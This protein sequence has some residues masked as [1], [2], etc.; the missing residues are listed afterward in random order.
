[1]K[2]DI[3]LQQDVMAE[4]QWEPS[5]HAAQIGVEVADGV[6]TLSGEVATYAEKCEAE[7]AAQRVFGVKALAVN[8]RVQLAALG[9]RSDVDI[10][11]TVENVL[12]WMTLGNKG[13]VQ[14]MVED[15]WITLTGTVDWQ[16][17][18]DAASFA[19]RHLMGVRGVS[20]QIVIKPKVSLSAVKADIEAALTRRALADAGKISVTIEGAEVTLSGQVN[21]WGERDSARNSAWGTPGVRN[22]VDNMTL[23]Y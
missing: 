23:G 1:M 4:L 6:V 8:L 20:N 19:V 15:G 12:E 2:T 14:V 11:R 16:Y 13:S 17:Q 22:V 7:R 18:Q 10:A 5:I 9:E 3:Q 21:S